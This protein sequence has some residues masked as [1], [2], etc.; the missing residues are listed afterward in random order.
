MAWY[1][2][3]RFTH[4]GRESLLLFI[5]IYIYVQGQ[6]NNTVRV[7]I[8]V[9]FTLPLILQVYYRYLARNIDRDWLIA[10]ASII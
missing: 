6:H 5:Y 9:G 2:C 7:E 8:E 10:A 4:A 3:I 1:C